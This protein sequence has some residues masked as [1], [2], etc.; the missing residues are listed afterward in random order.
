M[1]KFK[2]RP[3]RE[4]AK[5]LEEKS[6]L[7]TRG[8]YARKKEKKEY[9]SVRIA[10]S[11]REKLLKKSEELEVSGATL[12]NRLV[13]DYLPKNTQSLSKSELFKVLFDIHKNDTKP[14]DILDEE[15]KPFT[16][17]MEKQAKDIVAIFSQNTGISIGY[18]LSSLID[19][20][21]NELK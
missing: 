3:V 18:L 9:V 11:I 14:I 10:L 13:F 2:T 20:Y 1:K 6:D 19:Y 12:L 16:F 7:L 21:I 5:E 17:Y 15:K 4:F 8:G